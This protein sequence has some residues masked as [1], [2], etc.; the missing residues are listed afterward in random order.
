MIQLIASDMDGTLLDSKKRLPADF[1]DTILKLKDRGVLFAVASGR[2][3]AS[4]RRDLEPL[5]PH[6][7]FVCENGALVMEN[8][9]QLLIDPM[10]P[11]HVRDAVLACR[12][13]K[14]VY[15]V[16]CRAQTALIEASA[17][18]AFIADTRRYYPSASVV[19]DLLAHCHYEDVCKVAY[20]DE[21]DAQTHELPVLE[22]KLSD[23]LL[24]TLSGEHWVDSMKPG[25]TK[26]RA[27]RRLQEKLGIAPE[28][29]MAF[30]DYLNDYDLLESVGESYAM[31]NGHDRLKQMARYIAP[32]NDED[33]VMRVIRERFFREDI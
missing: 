15:P 20:Y 24:V 28:D 3:Y 9:R 16:V 26:G 4:L 21:G 7:L 5:V 22:E 1:L 29:C 14:G 18:P 32:S 25:V 17:D 11:A 13:L 6:I 8:D 12:G 33:G 23:R 2:Q 31:I 30:G 10:D 27:M 19:G